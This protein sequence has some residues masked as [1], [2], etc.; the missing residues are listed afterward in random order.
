MIALQVGQNATLVDDRSALPLTGALKDCVLEPCGL[1]VNL[2]RAPVRVEVWLSDSKPEF[3]LM[4]ATE[5]RLLSHVPGPG[6]TLY[7]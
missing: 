7:L 2:L 6:D 5:E 4:T 3:D 1:S